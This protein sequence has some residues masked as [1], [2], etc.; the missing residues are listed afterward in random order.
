MNNP[1]TDVFCK[2]CGEFVNVIYGRECANCGEEI[3][4]YDEESSSYEESSEED[5]E[6]E[7]DDWGEGEYEDDEYGYDE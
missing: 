4:G 2:H 6:Y 7:E 5:G 3:E 1:Y